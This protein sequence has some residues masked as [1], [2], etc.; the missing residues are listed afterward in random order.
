MPSHSHQSPINGGSN[1]I[2]TYGY[3]SITTGN[4]S[5]ENSAST[6]GDQP[7][8]NMQPYLILNYIIK[9]E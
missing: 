1:N 2:L 3:N 5:F 4:S 7:H 6:G 8:N 9:V